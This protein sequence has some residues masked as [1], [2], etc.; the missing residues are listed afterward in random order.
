MDRRR[1]LLVNPFEE[2]TYRA[3]S[4]AGNRAH[5]KVN[6]KTGVKDA[7]AIDNSGLTDTEYGY[8][9]KAH[10]DFVVVEGESK[11]VFAV[12]FDGSQHRTDPA[13][14]R[15]DRLKAS[16]C[17]KLGMP[18]LRIDAAF[19]RTV[20]RFTLVGWLAE[21]WF[22][23]DA[24]CQAQLAGLISQDDIFDY[25]SV[26]D[27]AYK[28]GGKPVEI[29]TSD[30]ESMKH[31]GTASIIFPYDPFYEARAYIDRCC[32]EERILDPVATELWAEEANGYYVGRALIRV[33]EGAIVGQS[34]CRSYRFP[35]VPPS[36]LASELAVLDA[37]NRL[38]A[39]LAGRRC[40]VSDET[41]EKL[42]CEKDWVVSFTC[43]PRFY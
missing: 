39:H 42:R 17:E 30:E 28:H 24:F 33:P 14:Q 41:V 36:E 34:R 29:S 19:L 37:T 20:G 21:L 25:G 9:L 31:L 13:T 5:F 10:F 2:K 11:C 8:A 15:R 27:L 3:L 1:N 7:I 35:P 40:T 22:L 6:M 43:D 12:E 18:L 4:E 38:E 23:N 32:R 16:I 26:V